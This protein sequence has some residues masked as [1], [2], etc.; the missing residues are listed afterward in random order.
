M[1]FQSDKRISIIGQNYQINTKRTKWS[2][3]GDATGVF[4]Q[5]RMRGIRLNGECLDKVWKSYVE[6]YCFLTQI[7]IWEVK[8]K[9]A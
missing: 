5:V 1:M 2:L 9:S 8:Q 3:P 6:S 4:K 7:K